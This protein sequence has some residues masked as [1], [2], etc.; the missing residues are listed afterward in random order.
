MKNRPIPLLRCLLCCLLLLGLLAA[1]GLLPPEPSSPAGPSDPASGSIATPE[2]TG[3][4]RVHFFDVAQADSALFIAPDG[5]TMLIDAGDVATKQELQEKLKKL[6]VQKIDILIGTHPH[7]DHIGGM[8]QIVENF[9]IGRIYLPDASHTSKTFQNLLQS[10]ADRKIPTYEAKA[11]VTFSLGNRVSCQMLA[12]C[13]SYDDLNNASAVVHVVYGEVS[14]LMTGDAETASEAD[15]LKNDPAALAS[16]VLKMG[17]HGSSTSSSLAFLD[18]VSPTYAVISCG[19]GNSYGHPHTETLEHLAARG[20][21][22]FRT[23]ELGDIC[24]QT[25]G[26]N[27]S[28]DKDGQ[29]PA[30]EADSLAYVYVTES[31]K[32]YHKE[33]CSALSKSKTKKRISLAEAK[34]Q[35]YSTCKRCFEN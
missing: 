17:H 3:T 7:S 6:G 10:I 28:F 22:T 34:E 15:M 27:L 11:G 33:D 23:D 1:C 25:D 21:V 20:I 26:V 5:A 2:A 13:Q 12:P 18:A 19:I 4:L 9:E 32:T 35:G 30:A 16:T 24:M 29:V 31:G 14:F 8:Q